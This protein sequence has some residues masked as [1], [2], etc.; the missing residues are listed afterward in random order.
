MNPRLLTCLVLFLAIGCRKPSTSSPTSPTSSPPTA[1]DSADTPGS[2]PNAAAET[3]QAPAS[4][5]ELAT[6]LQELT[7]VVRKYAMEKRQAPKSLDDLVSAGYLQLPPQPPPGK[8]FSI[9][10][11]LQVQLINR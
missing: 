8:K 2:S 9:D 10:R 7:Q 6:A 5:A 1:S 4:E 3:A 11:N